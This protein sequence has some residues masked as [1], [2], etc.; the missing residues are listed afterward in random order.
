MAL[1]YSFP[2]WNWSFFFFFFLMSSPNYSFLICTQITQKAGKVIWYVYLLNSF[3][4]F[5]VIH[6]IKSFGEV[7]KPEADVLLESP[8]F[9]NDSMKVGNL[10]SD[11][12]AF[13]KSILNIWKFSVHILLKTWL[14]NFQNCI[15]CMWDEYNFLIVWTFFDIAFLW[16]WKEN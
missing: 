11:S 16:D 7:S 5:V 4:H 2:I 8:C 1:M 12:S 10:M 13:S 15:A 3:P 9:F 14:E 6:A